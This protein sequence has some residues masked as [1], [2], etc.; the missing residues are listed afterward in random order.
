MNRQMT[1]L[2][3][4]SVIMHYYSTFC[5]VG[6]PN[7]GLP[8]WYERTVYTLIN[9]ARIAPSAYGNSYLSGSN[10]IQSY[11]SRTPYFIHDELCEAARYHSEDMMSC[12]KMQHT[13][14]N[15]TPSGTRIRSF[16]SVKPPATAECIAKGQRSPLSAVD[17]WLHSNKGHRGALM[18]KNYTDIGAGH[19][20]NSSHWWTTTFSILTKSLN[21][22]VRGGTHRFHNNSTL[23]FLI[24]LYGESGTTFKSVT[25]NLDGATI[26]C[27]KLFGSNNKVT[28]RTTSSVSSTCRYY[29]FIIVDSNNDTWRYPE[30]G[31][32]LTFGE[33]NCEKNYLEKVATQHPFRIK[34]KSQNNL[35]S[36]QSDGIY[37]QD[38]C[39]KNLIGI[40]WYMLN[41]R[42]KNS[43]SFTSEDKNKVNFFVPH[44]VFSPCI[45]VLHYSVGNKQAFMVK[46]IL[47]TEIPIK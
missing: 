45:V 21:H 37:F 35:V 5:Q 8:N 10:S 38:Q 44:A 32:F 16:L 4:F 9:A 42:L 18:S 12:G 14:C 20:Q 28:Y 41:G 29:Y 39:H 7:N 15:G 30:T 3:I 40:S 47:K 46:G 23:E 36:I 22:P 26:N 13:S 2:V 6:V 33:G 24:N 43:Y 27:D 31:A 17:A 34:A 19:A 11:S 25:L 1:K